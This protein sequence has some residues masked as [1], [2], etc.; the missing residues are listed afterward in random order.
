MNCSAHGPEIG[1]VAA[2]PAMATVEPPVSTGYPLAPDCDAS[3][4][5][6]CC[7]NA[8]LRYSSPAADTA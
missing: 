3:M 7:T 1:I 8:L 6:R 2:R 4:P 5:Y